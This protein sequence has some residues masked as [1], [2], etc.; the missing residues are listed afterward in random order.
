MPPSKVLLEVAAKV[1]EAVK[2]FDE[3]KGR[4]AATASEAEDLRAVLAGM[5]QSFSGNNSA[6]G[7]LTSALSQLETAV[8]TLIRA[9]QEFKDSAKHAFSQAGQGA[10]TLGKEVKGAVKDIQST[11]SKP[12]LD[13]GKLKKDTIGNGGSVL[14]GSDIFDP[15]LI[16]VFL[17]NSG[18]HR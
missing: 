15:D 10:H 16:P 12:A 1:D 8:N 14:Q 5:R 13:L 3:I 11:K 6:L 4:M 7:T 17:G 2:G 18:N 9:L